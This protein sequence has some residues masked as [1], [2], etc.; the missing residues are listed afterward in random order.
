MKITSSPRQGLRYGVIER[1]DCAHHLVGGGACEAVHGHTYEIEVLAYGPDAHGHAL[2]FETLKEKVI[3]QLKPYDHQD[4]NAFFATPTCEHFCQAIFTKMQVGLPG[5]AF[6]R[7][8]PR[9]T[10]CAAGGWATRS[11]RRSW[12][13]RW[14]RC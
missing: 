11:P 3:Q 5:L 7:V 2:N 10:R 9:R 12:P 13:G 4:L 6:V 14:K 8:C 1:I